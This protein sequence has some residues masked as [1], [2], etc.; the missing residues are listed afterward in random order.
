MVDEL[1]NLPVKQVNGATI[2]M[3]DV[4]HVR[5]GSP[6]Q[7][8]VVRMDGRRAVLMT[9]LKS[10]SASTLDIVDSVKAILP[11]LQADAAQSR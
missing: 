6:P 9:V 8:N 11:R 5:D 1:N 7:R 3:R 10:G 2:Y 4:A